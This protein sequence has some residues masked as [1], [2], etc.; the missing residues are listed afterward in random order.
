MEKSDIIKVLEPV[1]KAFDELKIFYY[2]GG[3][4]ASS[5]YGVGRSTLDIDMVSTIQPFQI[6]ILV[7]KL[8]DTFYIDKCMI[9]D[10]IKSKSS[11]NLIHLDTMIKLDIFI[12]LDNEYSIN[13]FQRK[14][15]DFID[16]NY[17]SLQVYVCSAED[18]IIN[19][20][21]WYKASDLKSEKQWLDIIG[22]LKVQCDLLDYD[23]LKSW[24]SELGIID[25]LEKVVLESKN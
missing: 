14:R 12:L 13:S 6:D 5:I 20:L 23:Y 18:I 10:A 4:V 17:K 2:I 25:L 7:G 8:K 15:K 9:E 16:E 21:L 3:S 19:K 1:I 22:V 24:A 11:F